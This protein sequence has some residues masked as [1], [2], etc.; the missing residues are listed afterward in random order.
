MFFYFSY[1][2]IMI[3]IQIIQSKYYRLGETSY[4]NT[5]T[6]DIKSFYNPKKHKFSY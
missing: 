6:D 5:D 3:Q 4:E 1:T 2:K